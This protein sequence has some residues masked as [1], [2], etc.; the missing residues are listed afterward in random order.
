MKFSSKKNPAQ[1]RGFALKRV[2]FQTRFIFI[3]TLI[4]NFIANLSLFW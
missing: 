4:F 3:F 2:V 1:L